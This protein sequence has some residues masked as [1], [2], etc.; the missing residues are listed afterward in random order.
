M[1]FFL[2]SVK[3]CWAMPV[4]RDYRTFILFLKII[5]PLANRGST[6]ST[7]SL[8]PFDPNGS[9]N[10]AQKSAA[11]GVCKVTPCAF[12]LGPTGILQQQKQDQFVDRVPKAGQSSTMADFGRVPSALKVTP[13]NLPLIGKEVSASQPAPVVRSKGRG[14]RHTAASTAFASDI[15]FQSSNAFGPKNLT[16]YDSNQILQS[17]YSSSSSLTATTGKEF[18]SHV[19]K[20]FFKFGPGLAQA[21]MLFIH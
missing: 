10:H 13:A 21:L 19:S 2:L 14:F 20:N 5:G 16:N 4:R 3:Y 17:C 11:V 7:S 6:G 9:L 12:S 8:I 15:N 1:N 18:V